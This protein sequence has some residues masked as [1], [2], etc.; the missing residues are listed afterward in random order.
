MPSRKRVALVI[1]N[2][3]A[4]GAERV[5][6]NLIEGLSELG[7]EVQLVVFEAV[8][9]LIADVPLGTKVVDLG[10][11]R[12]YRSP[13]ALARYLR[14]AKPAVMVGTEGHVNIAIFVARWLAA[15]R[16]RLVFTEH[17]AISQVPK[18][19]KDRLYRVLARFAYRRADAVVAVSGGVA[20]S[21]ARGVGLPRDLIS[22][23]YNPV[24]TKR[25]WQTASEPVDDPWFGPDQPPVILG[26]GRLAAQKDFPTLLKAFARVRESREANLMILGE[27]PDRAALEAQAEALGLS[28]HVRFPGFV[29][30]PASYMSNAS[31]FALSSVREGLPTVLIEALAAGAP[32]VSTDCESGPR[33]ILDGGRLGRLV[34]VDDPDR[35]GA[36]IVA[37]LD[38]GRTAVDVTALVEYSPREAAR[39]YLQVAGSLV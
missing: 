11:K 36:A 18:G 37:A 10:C 23:V 30:K 3:R 22:V 14:S 24:L 26:V 1:S 13:V 7:C 8:G 25:F 28:S 9:E 29:P 6:L 38:E 4:G 19:T 20:D 2:L 35:L 32:V 15:A 17:L 33:E 39:R 21:V 16:T 12:A 31:V 27:G 34:P 5:T